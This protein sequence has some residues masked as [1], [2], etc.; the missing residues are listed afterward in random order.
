M[1]GSHQSYRQSSVVEPRH[2]VIERRR[3]GLA[4]VG[5]NKSGSNGIDNRSA[6][7]FYPAGIGNA[8]ADRQSTSLGV[9]TTS[10]AS[11]FTS[12]F[13]HSA[14][15]EAAVTITYKMN[16]G[17]VRHPVENHFGEPL[18]HV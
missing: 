1:A 9:S 5:N 8:C 7:A 14:G 18:L 4:Q 10:I 3:H 11:T 13:V 12:F 17:V 2:L 6:T 15:G 16:D